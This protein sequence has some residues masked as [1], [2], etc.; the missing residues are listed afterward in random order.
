M[1][2]LLN[3]WA[4]VGPLMGVVLGGWLTMRNQRMLWILDNKRSEYRKLLTTITR[5]Y[6]TFLN[7]YAGRVALSGADERRREK[8]HLEAL[9]VIRDRLFI[10]KEVSEM[11]IASKWS[12]AI[13]RAYNNRDFL[14]LKSQYE[15]IAKAIQ[16]HAGKIMGRRFWFLA[17]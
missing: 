14:A 8:A 3:I 10:A 13:G 11:D 17:R 15:E 2:I 6:T 16:D 1:R 4:A 7:V 9:N 5:D 12:E